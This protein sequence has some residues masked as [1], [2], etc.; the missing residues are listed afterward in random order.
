MWSDLHAAGHRQHGSWRPGPVR[1]EIGETRDGTRL[2][3]TA[4]D[5]TGDTPK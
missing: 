4:K 1:Y 2:L 5:A 3:G